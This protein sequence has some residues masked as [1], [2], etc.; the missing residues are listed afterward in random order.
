MYVKIAHI[1]KEYSKVPVSI[2]KEDMEEELQTTTSSY[3]A[4]T[5][6]QSL[7]LLKERPQTIIF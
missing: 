3:K 7:F 1:M 5:K 6:K 4:L 2:P